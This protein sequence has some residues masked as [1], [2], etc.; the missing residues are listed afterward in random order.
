MEVLRNLS[1]VQKGLLAGLALGILAVYSCL[2]LSAVGII[3]VSLPGLA[4]PVAQVSTATPIPPTATSMSNIPTDEPTATATNRPTEKPTATATNRPTDKP[5]ATATSK[6]TV[7]PIPATVMVRNLPVTE[8]VAADV[9]V[10]GEVDRTSTKTETKSPSFFAV[11]TPTRTTGG[12]VSKLTVAVSPT[13]ETTDVREDVEAVALNVQETTAPEP[14]ILASNLLVSTKAASASPQE[15]KPLPTV[16]MR[17]ASSMEPGDATPTP[18]WTWR[19]IEVE[20]KPG[21]MTGASSTVLA[22]RVFGVPDR[23]VHIRELSSGLSTTL[24]TGRKPQYGDYADDVTGLPAATYVVTPDGIDVPVEVRLEPGDFVLVEFALRPPLEVASTTRTPETT[25]VSVTKGTPVVQQKMTATPTAKPT[26]APTTVQPTIV[27]TEPAPGQIVADPAATESAKAGWTWQGVVCE[28][29]TNTGS[30]TG[31]IAVRVV[32]VPDRKVFVE[33]LSGTWETTLL[34]GRKPEYGRFSDGVG[35][36]GPG[37]YRIAPLD[38]DAEVTI[39]LAQ[40][41][42]VLV[43]FA[44][45]P[46]PGWTQETTAAPAVSAEDTTAPAVQP[47]HTVLPV[48]PEPSTQ[49]VADPAATESAKA[50]WTW[51]GVVYEQRRDTGDPVGIIAVRIVDVPERK[52]FLQS[53]SDTWETTLVTGRKPEYGRFSDDVGGLGPGTYTI[54]PMDIDAQVTVTLERGDFVLVEFALR[55]D[56]GRTPGSGTA[57]P[58]Q[59]A[60]ETA[61]S[62]VVQSVPVQVPGQVV[63]D[64]AATVS[65]EAGWTWQG[66]EYERI[67][68]KETANSTGTIAVRVVEVPDRKVS[69]E[70]LSGTWATTLT[71]GDKSEYGRFADAVGGLSPG[72]YVIKPMD[73]DAEVAVNL[74]TGDFVLVEFALRPIPGWTPG[75][76]TVQVTVQPTADTTTVAVSAQ[77]VPTTQPSQ[78]PVPVPTAVTQE[79]SWQGVEYER[80]SGQQTGS[81]AGVIAVR[82]V[83]VPDRKV[84]IAETSGGWN[85]TLTTGNKPEFGD[86][87]DS[88]GGLAPG[89]YT[90]KPMD[91]DDEVTVQLEKGDFVLVEFALRPGPDWK[92]DPLDDLRDAAVA[93]AGVPTPTLIPGWTW[94]GREVERKAGVATGN[95]AGKLVV[96]GIALPNWQATVSDLSGGWAMSVQLEQH[97]EYGNFAGV[98]EGLAPGT[99]VVELAGG[100]GAPA[101][102]S[103]GQGDSV[104]L[105]FFP[106]AAQLQ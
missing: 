100:V 26:M 3:P 7:T 49:I 28:Q 80:R 84:F 92:P 94:E 42:F 13:L 20:R 98:L 61:V 95:A 37:T 104:L 56:P 6:P 15:E 10:T 2:C 53:Q 65:A 29:R 14:T 57:L 58:V 17:L 106:R 101:Q 88:V 87:A 72:T 96:R 103:I 41:D 35:G 45:R 66:V 59:P 9:V 70:A 1:G 33:E 27:P 89:S 55:P 91:I 52:V 64:P 44:L 24:V 93:S 76:V 5:T 78:S 34:T 73:I 25:A 31:T 99:Y 102:V 21:S 105:E 67:S 75:S 19:G 43:E 51:Q 60:A 8:T 46:M 86:F 85:A 77:P 71:T 81:I 47:V 11:N 39:N 79:W 83:G 40:G 54:K 16:V 82:V 22:V 90:I 12:A 48:A 69:V 32:E 38:I 4:K 74:E 30:P 50:G 18:E 36:L 23:E 63:A 68:G 97:P 62:P